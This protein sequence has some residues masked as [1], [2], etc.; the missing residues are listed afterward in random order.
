M[1]GLTRFI[2]SLAFVA[3]SLAIA[4]DFIGKVVK[5]ID[6]DS[7][8]VMH[9][10]KAEQVRLNGIDC[11]EKGQPFWKKAK[12]ATSSLSFGKDV[13]VHAAQWTDTAEPLP[14]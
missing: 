11:P 14:R 3:P 5:V 4:D 10:G 2:A 13:T 12:Q 1:K 6:G 7:I 9:E 8:A